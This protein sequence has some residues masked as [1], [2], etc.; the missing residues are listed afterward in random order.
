[1]AGMLVLSIVADNI[2][3]KWG[4]VSTAAIMALG[5]IAMTASFPI[6][7]LNSMFLMFTIAFGFYGFG[8]GGEYPISASTAAEKAQSMAG[9]KNTDRGATISMTFSCQGAGA[10][11]GSVIILIMLSAFNQGVPDCN[12][13]HNNPTGLDTSS[14]NTVWRTTY[15]LGTVMTIGMLCYRIF[16]LE[17]SQA[18]K[19]L[20]SR[21][22]CISKIF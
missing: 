20:R 11:F 5:A 6:S 8:V 22:V 4:S 7:G 2:G 10:V 13:A 15:G 12:D 17:E 21:L 9:R 3:R 16:S 18:W 14:L 19:N 1:M